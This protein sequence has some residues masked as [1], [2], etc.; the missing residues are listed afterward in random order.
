[1]SARFAE[2][3][4]PE[5]LKAKLRAILGRS[6]KPWTIE[7]LSDALNVGVSRV[8]TA[9]EQLADDRINIKSIGTALFLDD[10]PLRRPPTTIDLRSLR[11]GAPIRF[12][13]TGDN[14]LGSKYAR[15]DVLN[16]L[17]DIW[18]SEGVKT[19]YQCGNMIDGEARFN[20]SD[21]IVHGL[22]PQVDYFVE[23]WPHRK[24][25][26][27]HFITG[28]DH[29]GWYVQRENVDIGQMM[30]DRA[31]RFGRTDLRYLGHM[32]HDL[33][34]QQP[35]GSA[36]VRLVHA[37]GGSAYATSYTVQKIVESYQGGEKPNV[38][39]AGHYHKAEYGY[40]REV[41]CVQVGC[42]E[43]QTPFMRKKK[44]EA[45]VGG[46]IVELEQDPETG[47]I[48]GFTPKLI[49]YFNKGYYNGRWS[50]GGG[51]QLPARGVD[52]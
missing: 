47:A 34:F 25:I 30:Q 23:H 26:T 49:R 48:V 3:N 39:L 12:G 5:A 14:H 33:L 43:D 20:R 27:T 11:T 22:D 7:Q 24:G 13:V 9:A 42:T 44:L 6:K 4:A 50:H 18:E 38:L 32:E 17:Y 19:V 1:M 45:H 51:V 29:E 28:D 8:R 15:L 41:H 21:L 35:K 52:A 46:A 2:S 36:H 10:S 37:G 31:E 40:P 16:A